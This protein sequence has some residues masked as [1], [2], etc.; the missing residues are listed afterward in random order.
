MVIAKNS[1][2]RLESNGGWTL[3]GWFYPGGFSSHPSVWMKSKLSN[4]QNSHGSDRTRFANVRRETGDNN[5]ASVFCN[6]KQVKIGLEI[7]SS[8]SSL[9]AAW[10]SWMVS[11]SL[12]RS[13]REWKKMGIDVEGISNDRHLMHLLLR[14]CY[15]M[16]RQRRGTMLVERRSNEG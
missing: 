15:E 10:H 12:A 14:E 13:W 3:I 2:A 16:G 9:A 7:P 4:V 5:F 6:P 8:F 11:P 1:D